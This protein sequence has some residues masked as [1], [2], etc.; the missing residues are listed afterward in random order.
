MQQWENNTFALCHVDGRSC[1]RIKDREKEREKDTEVI[2]LHVKRMN[3]RRLT[4]QV[5]KTIVSRQIGVLKVRSVG[6]VERM[7]ERRLTKRISKPGC[8]PGNKR[9]EGQIFR[10]CKT[11]E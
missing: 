3:E 8:E 7:T 2:R 10:T 6:H 9:I 1:T 4:K 11:S 5:F